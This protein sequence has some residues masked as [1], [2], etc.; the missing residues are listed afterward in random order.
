MCTS[1][2]TLPRDPLP[3]EVVGKINRTVWASGKNRQLYCPNQPLH[4]TRQTKASIITHF[5]KST[6]HSLYSTSF[7]SISPRPEEVEAQTG[8]PPL[9]RS[10]SQPPSLSPSQPPP[11]PRLL[12]FLRHI[13]SR[14]SHPHPHPQPWKSG[15]GRKTF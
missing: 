10:S 15:I 14:Y 12:P 6:N 3:G 11:P 9:R 4:T 7:L 13:I 1:L 8:F 5:F 2:S